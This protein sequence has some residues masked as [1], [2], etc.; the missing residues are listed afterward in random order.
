MMFENIRHGGT[1]FFFA[2]FALLAFLTTV[3]YI[4]ETRF[5][6][7]RFPPSQTSFHFETHS[8]TKQSLE[9]MDEVFGD[10]SSA[11]ERQRA[12]RI[13]NELGLTDAATEPNKAGLEVASQV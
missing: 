2:A 4:P 5:K 9:E 1:F 10:R 7:R 13:A 3:F 11:D 8:G 12:A 6:V